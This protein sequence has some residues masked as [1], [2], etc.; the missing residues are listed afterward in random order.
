M[1]VLTRRVHEKIVIETPAGEVIEVC[2]VGVSG[3]QFKIGVKAPKTTAVDREEI[4]QRK[5]GNP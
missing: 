3:S 5:R 2:V 1:L 4:A